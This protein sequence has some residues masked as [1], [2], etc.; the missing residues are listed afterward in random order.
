MIGFGQDLP[1]KPTLSDLSAYNKDK[2]FNVTLGMDRNA[3]VEAMGG[4]KDIQTWVKDFISTPIPFKNWL[5]SQPYDRDLF[6]NNKGE[7]CEILWYFTGTI[8]KTKINN[9]LEL[10][11]SKEITKEKLTPIIF[12]NNSVTGL[13]WGYY[14]DY[15]KQNN[16][17]LEVKEIE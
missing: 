7:H 11:K 10:E 4:R 14:T 2:L 5:I 12:T 3:V 1:K 9:N 15:A 8:K 6:T 13:G 16:I 17:R